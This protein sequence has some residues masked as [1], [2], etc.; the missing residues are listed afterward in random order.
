MKTIRSFV[1][2]AIMLTVGFVAK[3]DNDRV[4]TFQELPQQSKE[5]VKA[6]F[7]NKVPMIVT[8]DWDDYEIYFESGEKIEFRKDGTWKSIESYTNGVPA[9]L[10]PEKIKDA[11]KK[12]YPAT[13]IIKI[14]QDRRGYE[15]KLNNGMEIEFN[16][17]FQVIGFDD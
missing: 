13:T 11:V 9:V 12:S 1:L 5:L 8:A 3:A 2:L 10:V 17:L 4:I 15:V 7:G 16:S 14:E 6:H